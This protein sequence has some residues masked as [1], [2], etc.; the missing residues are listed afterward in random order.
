MKVTDGRWQE[1]MSTYLSEVERALS[2]VNHPRSQE[3]LDDL[4]G[5]AVPTS[6]VACAPARR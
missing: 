2:L 6:A 4:R 5:R 3:V 1:L